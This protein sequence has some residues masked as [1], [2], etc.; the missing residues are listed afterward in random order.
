MDLEQPV[1]RISVRNLVEFILRSGDI[2]NRTGGSDKDAMQ[3]GGRMH[4]KIQKSMGSDYH[5]EV[6]LKYEIP[7]KGFILSLEGRADGIIETPEGIIVDEIKG[8][9]KE[10]DK[11]SE[12]VPVHQAQAK[13]YAYIYARQRK[14]DEIGVQ[15]TYCNLDTEDIKRFQNVFLF[16][17]L[18]CWFW[19]L[20]GKY[21]KWARYQIQW[22]KKRNESIREIEF[23]FEYREGQKKLVTSVD[24]EK[25]KAVYSGT[26][27]SRKNNCNRVSGGESSRRRTGRENFLSDSKNDYQNSGMAGF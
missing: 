13:C 9:F 24:I 22:R 6:V 16:R 12:P 2:D 14:L 7:C 27:R 19:D 26:D 8:V 20:I 18:D 4:R 5:A 23:P 21:E 10:L 15:M 17:E 3:Q 25:E 11:L 1:I